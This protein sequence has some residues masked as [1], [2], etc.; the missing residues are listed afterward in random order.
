MASLF[1]LESLKI[2]DPL[3]AFAVH[4]ACGV[5]GVLACALFSTDYYVATVVGPTFGEGGVFYGGSRMIQTALVFVV[6]VISW[7]GL[8]S[9]LLFLALKRLGVLRIVSPTGP[10]DASPRAPAAS[11][12]S[13]S[14]PGVAMAAP[15]TALPVRTG[16]IAIELQQRLG[17]GERTYERPYERQGLTSISPTESPLDTGRS[18]GTEPVSTLSSLGSQ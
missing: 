9:T 6:C 2:D 4:G 18:N 10:A 7:V 13:A 11:R 17:S 16:S 3:D 5:W 12:A 15:A 1:V 8:N 14:A